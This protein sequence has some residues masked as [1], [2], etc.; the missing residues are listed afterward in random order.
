[1][2]GNPCSKHERIRFSGNSVPPRP[3]TFQI[4]IHTRRPIEHR[5]DR[6]GQWTI[7][8]EYHGRHSTG[9][10]WDDSY[11]SQY[12]VSA[13]ARDLRKTIDAHGH[14]A[15]N[16]HGH[17]IPAAGTADRSPMCWD[18]RTCSAQDTGRTG[19]PGLSAVRGSAAR[20]S[21]TGAISPPRAR[22]RPGDE[23]TAPGTRSTS[24]WRSRR[25]ALR[26]SSMP[27]QN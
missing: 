27:G 15:E 2:D 21:R 9:D 14:R 7:R 6:L 22:G 12:G 4:E 8:L 1:M 26:R 25:L 20:F 19:S 23:E 18:H 3:H 16:G 5:A 17:K 11:R 10:R 13:I 24:A